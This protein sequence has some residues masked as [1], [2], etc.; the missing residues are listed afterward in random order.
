MKGLTSVVAL[1][2]L[3]ALAAGCNTTKGAGEDIANTGKNIQQGLNASTGNETNE[4]N[5]TGMGASLGNNTSMNT[6]DN[7]T[8][9]S[10]MGY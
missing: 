6:S 7:M 9:E 3:I 10:G 5:E 2:A 4:T 1:F 8:N